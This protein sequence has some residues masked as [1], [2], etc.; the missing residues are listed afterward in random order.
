V[1]AASGRMPAYVDTGLNLVHV[2]DVAAGHVLALEKGQIGRRYILG[3]Q[4]A[5]LG[6]ML[7]AIAGLTGRR[8]PTLKLPLAPLAPLARVAEAVGRLTGREPFLT[9][10]ALK[11]A[12]H[13]MYFTSARAEAELGYHARPYAEALADA[14]SWFRAAGRIR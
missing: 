9:Q 5:A 8:A 7:A 13:K 12:H 1:E 14:V 3:G 4:D 10:D 6:D 2:D 11:M